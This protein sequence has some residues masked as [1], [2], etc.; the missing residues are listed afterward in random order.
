MITVSKEFQIEGGIGPYEYEWITDPNCPV[1]IN[2]P[3]G[4]SNGFISAEFSFNRAECIASTNIYVKVVDTEGCTSNIPVSIP[5]PCV[6]FGILNINAATVGDSL[7]LTVVATDVVDSYEWSY[8]KNIY[9][10]VS[11]AGNQ[12]TLR[13]IP[14]SPR[15][16]NSIVRVK[17][18]NTLGCIATMEYI[19]NFC[20]P[21]ATNAQ[22]QV[23]SESGTS[24]IVFLDVT[25]CDTDI[26]WTSLEIAMPIAGITFTNTNNELFLQTSPDVPNGNYIL[27]YT[28]L[29]ISRGISNRANIYLEVT[30]CNSNNTCLSAP[31]SVINIQCVDAVGTVTM[32]DVES[33][34]FSECTPDWSTFKFK[35]NGG[36]QTAI[37]DT[38]LNLPWGTLEFTANHKIVYNFTSI[39]STQS[40]IIHWC[41]GSTN[42]GNTGTVTLNI[43]FNCNPAPIPTNET[44][45]IA[46]VPPYEYLDVLQNTTGEVNP[47]SI[48]ITEYPEPTTGSVTTN[49][50]GKVLFTPAP[51]Y[52]GT[53]TFK[54]KVADFDNNYSNEVE[55]TVKVICAGQD[56]EINICNQ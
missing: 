19:Q 50:Q 37:S 30:A 7:L 34:L 41:L 48:S 22:T 49:S 11:Q 1:T 52:E 45:C 55:I 38:M 16:S 26:D 4:T 32:L 14:N 43:N 56:A 2:S 54:Y 42:G 23:C 28:V 15:V 5:N 6:N 46:C 53:T 8:D 36:F 29:D 10:L 39:P 35:P 27:T 21:V 33:I 20:G 25:A 31:D 13:R 47:L 40:E 9:E 44:F 12:L 3:S 18:T 51:S 24:S 17:A